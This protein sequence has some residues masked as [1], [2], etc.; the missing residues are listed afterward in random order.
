MVEILFN[1]AYVFYAN[2]FLYWWPW[3]YISFDISFLQFT[4]LYLLA[5]ILKARNIYYILL[6]AFLEVFIFGLYLSLLQL[7]LFTGFL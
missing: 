3:V 6:Y 2:L 1:L 5:L 4:I 7:E